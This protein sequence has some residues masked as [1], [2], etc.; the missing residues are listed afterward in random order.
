MVGTVEV[1]FEGSTRQLSYLTTNSPYS[2]PYLC[3]MAVS[4]TDQRKG[5]GSMLVSAV[6]VAC[7][8]VGQKECYLHLRFKDEDSAGR[9]YRAKGFVELERDP[10]WVEFLGQ[11]RKK[12][13]KKTL[14]S[15]VKES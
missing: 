8:A 7:L 3:N 14:G 10:F 13:M 6:E 5:I 4:P 15:D 2:S 12:L 1:S 9:L 11:E